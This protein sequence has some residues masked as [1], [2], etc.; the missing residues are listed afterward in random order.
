MRFFIAVVILLSSFALFAGPK[1]IFVVESYHKDFSWDLSYKNGLNK[2]LSSNYNL[3]YFQMDTKRL[4]S[5]KFQEMADM[6]W[7][8]YK[9]L[10]PTLVI[11]CDD[12][13][14]KFLGPKFK[15]EDIPVIFLGI[16]NNPRNYDVMDS[17]NITGVLERPLFK[18]SIAMLNSMIKMKRVLIL[19]DTGTTAKAIKN[20]VYGVR[21][22]TTFNGVDAEIKLVSNTEEWKKSVLNSKKDGY[23]AIIFGLYHTIVDRDGNYVEPDEIIEWSST[24]T[25]IPPFAF[26][27]FSVGN[28]KAIGGY[29]L[30]GEDQGIE[31]GKMAL[32]ILSSKE[33]ITL[34]P[35]TGKKGRF[36]FSKKQ[37]KRWNIDLPEIIANKSS[38]KQ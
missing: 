2:I 26:W 12:N 34:I 20:E 15:E 4:P 35:R 32:E 7:L 36:L 19:F 17:K 28:D 29:V 6:A 38:Y 33:D 13:A 16:N 3:Q 5:S 37:L 25:P 9:E 21:N 8:R 22:S 27:D 18:R 24:N 14:L 11:L 10:D 1:D 31:A 23:D 30:F